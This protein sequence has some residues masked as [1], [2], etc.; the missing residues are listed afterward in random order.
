MFISYFNIDKKITK[1]VERLKDLRS[2]IF[3]NNLIFLLK[4]LVF[5]ANILGGSHFC[6]F[7]N[8]F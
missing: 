4:N 5:G 6:P 3:A 1:F 7:Q 8:A 2:I